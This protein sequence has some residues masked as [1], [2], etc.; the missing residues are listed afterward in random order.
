MP[1]PETP[2]AR[3][4]YNFTSDNE[5]YLSLVNNLGVEDAPAKLTW[6]DIEAFVER[7]D[8]EG[9]LSLLN[10]RVNYHFQRYLLGQRGKDVS[11]KEQGPQHSEWPIVATPAMAWSLRCAACGFTTPS[12]KVLLAHFHEQ[13]SE[14]EAAARAEKE[15]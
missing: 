1:E 6:E 4:Q 12:F 15:E 9:Q 11:M 7:V 10:S 3:P 8:N 14:L 2:Y 13:H 5:L